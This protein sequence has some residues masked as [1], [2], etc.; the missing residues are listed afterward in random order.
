MSDQA[1]PSGDREL[2]EAGTNAPGFP[3]STLG[4]RRPGSAPVQKDM[5][6]LT[7]PSWSSRRSFAGRLPDAPFGW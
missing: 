2:A 6:A 4:T 7:E 3:T 5:A 1:S